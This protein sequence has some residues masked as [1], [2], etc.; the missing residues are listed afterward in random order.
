MLTNSPKAS[1]GKLHQAFY[2]KHFRASVPVNMGEHGY[3]ADFL[4]NRVQWHSTKG[5]REMAATGAKFFVAILHL[6]KSG[7]QQMEQDG[8]M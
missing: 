4:G 5:M 2:I 1:A 8:T 3:W 7:A 6:K